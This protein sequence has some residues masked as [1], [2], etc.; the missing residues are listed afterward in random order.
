MAGYVAILRDITEEKRHEK[1]K[2]DLVA[3]LSHDMRN[4]IS[5]INKTLELLS[6][7]RIGSINQKQEHVIRL[8]SNTNDHLCSM[9]NSFLDIF[10]EENTN[11]QLNKT[12]F[13]LD[14]VI[15]D[16][17]EEQSLLFADKNLGIKWLCS[18]SCGQS[19]SRLLMLAHKI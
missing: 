4:P 12:S 3:M 14:T 10:R 11:F 15:K 8:A 17:I 1:M 18:I 6:T 16:C 5:A 9:V 13:N 7:E 19:E 2:Q